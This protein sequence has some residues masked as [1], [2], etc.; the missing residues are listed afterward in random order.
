MCA[1]TQDCIAVVSLSNKLVLKLFQ[2]LFHKYCANKLEKLAISA[3]LSRESAR[4]A[5]APVVHG[6]LRAHVAPAYRFYNSAIAANASTCTL[7][8][9]QISAKSGNP[10]PRYWSFNKFSRP[11]YFRGNFL[12]TWTHVHVCY[13]SSPVCLSVTFVHPTQ[14]NHIFGNVYMPFG[15]MAICWH[16]EK[17]LRRSS[18]ENSSVGGVK[19]KRGSQI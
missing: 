10:W 17:I 19:P 11:A 1:W 9:Y 13:M 5:T 6:F 14:A 18:Q 8:M 7:Y 15:T 3:A 4:R 16:P 2:F 12:R